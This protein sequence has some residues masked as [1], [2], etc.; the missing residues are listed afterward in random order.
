MNVKSLTRLAPLWAA[1]L[2]STPHLAWSQ[3]SS[4]TRVSSFEY[5]PASGQLIREV[6]EPDRPNDCLSTTYGHDAWGNRSSSSTTACA[7]ASGDTLLSASTARTSA[8]SFESHTVTIGTRLT[9][10]VPAG[11]FA[12]RI[13]NALG[14]SE[15]RSYDPR[16]GAVLSLTG[17]NGLSTRWEY[18]G[19]GRK[20]KELRADG[21]STGWLY[22]YC[23][24]VLP[25]SS[26]GVACPSLSGGNSPAFVFTQS[27][28]AA[29]ST[30]MAADKVSYVDALGRVLR[31]QTQDF[32]GNTVVQDNTYNALGQLVRSTQPYVPGKTVYATTTTYDAL[33]RV[34]TQ[35]SPDDQAPGGVA[36]TSYN[37]NGLSVTV[38]NPKGQTKT[39]VKNVAGQTAQVTDHDGNQ[40]LYSYDA[41]SQLIQTN[42]AGQITT[43]SYDQRG[44]KIGM[45]D[46]AMGVW[47]YAYNAFGEL[48][49]QTDS[50]GQVSTMGYDALGRMTTKNEPDLKS[51]W[52]FD[53]DASGQA[54][55]KSVGKL[56]E[57][58]SDNGYR[59]LHSY[60]GLGRANSTRTAQ[61]STQ[62]LSSVSVG[63]DA[64]TGRMNSQ[65]W[66]TGYTAS[67]GYST[68][69]YLQTV[70]GSGS[71]MP[72]TQLDNLKY[73]SQGRLTS[74]RQ[75]G[76]ITTVK[77]FDQATG[78]LKDIQAQVD[79]Q[80][81]G[82]VFKQTYSY[83]SLSNLTA[84]SDANT[85]VQESYGYD[86]LNRL[87]TYTSLGGSVS[88]PT[89]TQVVYDARGNIL[90]K[91]DVGRYWYDSQRPN[92]L[93]NITLEGY[94]G[95]QALTG[96]RA[97]SYVFDDYGSTARSNGSVP[98]GNGNLMYTVSH[99]NASGKHTVR[100]E[101][102]T[103][104]NMPL[105]IRYGNIGATQAD[106]GQRQ[107]TGRHG[108]VQLPQRASGQRQHVHPNT[109]GRGEL[110]HQ[111][112]MVVRE[113][114]M[115]PNR[116]LPQRLWL[117]G[118]HLPKSGQHPGGQRELQLP[119][120]LQPV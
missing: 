6:I 75:G 58:R 39:T 3:T 76:R 31:S 117:D 41:L 63:F 11:Q 79:G 16:T 93:A 50:L 21:T 91:S 61:D 9:L 120:R 37:Y 28:Y 47:S 10:V 42:A 13:T 98:M 53:R 87:R 68:F 17:P 27:E 71:G 62:A 110:C 85:G 74:Y 26:G 18:D 52:F 23:T 40:V 73:D 106:N 15:T 116:S 115:H 24:T 77:E 109:D 43:L 67:Y 112:Q 7:G 108:R 83:D 90:Y 29:N 48:V 111:L 95:A 14:Q 118:E 36:T 105:E 22:Q 69:G 96:T 44:R 46:P 57:A 4:I 12:T 56:C 8:S 64:N 114:P 34:L 92:R 70:N 32:S 5:D 88:P 97:L 20:T 60:D 81:A 72:G 59:R 102:Y 51:T 38:T 78:R 25:A 100:W 2:L 86:N 89:T 65:S 119:Q 66:P 19:F 103:S 84:K 80:A 1:L 54:C 101:S 35:S 82:S 45:N 99:D 107:H 94:A 113:V 49:R 30:K 33:G 104:F 55:G